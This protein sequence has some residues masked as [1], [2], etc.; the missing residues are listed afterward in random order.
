MLDERGRSVPLHVNY[1]GRFTYGLQAL[2]IHAWDDSTQL[3]VGS[4]N[5]IAGGV[6]VLL[7]GNHR[8]DWLTTFPFGHIFG[9]LFPEGA[10]YGTSGHPATKGDVTI[11]NDC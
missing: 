9:S 3:V 4:F 2:K 10:V 11:E 6:T 8:T 7:G 5:S 1:K